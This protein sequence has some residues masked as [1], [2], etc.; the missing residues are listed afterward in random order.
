M[1]SDSEFTDKKLTAGLMNG[2][3]AAFTEIYNR[4]WKKLLAI[5][6]HHTKS[7]PD[8]EEIVQEVFLDLWSRKNNTAI[9]SLAAYLA[10]AVKFS[11]FKRLQRQRRRS[12]ILKLSYNISYSEPA[13]EKIYARFLDEYI[14]GIVEKLPEKC[15]LVFKYSRQE[16]KTIPEISDEMNIARKTVEGHL[17][18]ALKTLR[19]QLREAGV[20]FSFLLSILFK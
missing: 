20:L 3:K 6:Y 8:A 10:T 12:D 4:Y 14:N 19:I 16:G 2:D 7:K 9:E 18:K 5:A 17:T 13:E 11:I 15:R 1:I